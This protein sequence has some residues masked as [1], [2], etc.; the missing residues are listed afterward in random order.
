[1]N[2]WSLDANIKHTGEFKDGLFGKDSPNISVKIGKKSIWDIGQ[3]LAAAVPDYIF[4]THPFEFR[5]TVFFGK[6]QW[7]IAYEYDVSSS[8]G[9]SSDK[10]WKKVANKMWVKEKQKPYA[11]WHIFNSYEDIIDNKIRASSQG[12]YTNVVAKF[13]Y[14]GTESQPSESQGLAYADQDI[15]PQYQKTTIIDTGMFAK[16]ALSELRKVPVLGPVQN[17]FQWATATL[18]GRTH[19]LKLLSENIARSTVRDFM[20]DMYRGQ[21]IVLG[22]P[23]VKPYDYMYLGDVYNEMLGTC[24]VKEVTHTLTAEGGFVTTI[25]PDAAVANENKDIVSLW[26]LCGAIGNMLGIKSGAETIKSATL[27]A[28]ASSNAGLY[29]LGS[30]SLEALS[31]ISTLASSGATSTG[32]VA[33]ESAVGG[34]A[35]VGRAVS[36]LQVVANATT[37]IGSAVAGLSSGVSL[38]IGAAVLFFAG[39]AIDE[40]VKEIYNH[41]QCI[42]IN[43]LTYHGKEFS[44]GIQGHRGITVGT[45]LGDPNITK[46]IKGFLPKFLNDKA[47]GLGADKVFGTL[48]ADNYIDSQLRH[49]YY[50]SRYGEQNVYNP[51]NVDMEKSKENN[52]TSSSTTSPKV[53]T[54]APTTKVNPSPVNNTLLQPKAG[55]ATIKLTTGEKIARIATEWEGT[56]FVAGGKTKGKGVDNLNYILGVLKELGIKVDADNQNALYTNQKIFGFIDGVFTTTVPVQLEKAQPGD[57][58]FFNLGFDADKKEDKNKAHYIGIITHPEK[59]EFICASSNKESRNVSRHTWGREIFTND[60]ILGVRRIAEKQISQAALNKALGG[61]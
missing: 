61:D 50:L 45:H 38:L 44:A 8:A 24:G 58:I 42:T 9:V 56:P 32:V 51:Y 29:G 15:F 60:R 43:L 11:Q 25:E 23:T 6:P 22:D 36:G 55:P 17:V 20:K 35:L 12:V 10:S 59:K 19:V 52:K 26:A 28:V 37:A 27:A 47:E 16:G 40:V 49:S 2:P 41:F 5:S 13:Q 3:I 18:L 4:T 54:P 46:R 21:L 39:K 48:Y 34:T 57:F 14:N 30:K 7:P 1:M 31:R 33:L 53:D